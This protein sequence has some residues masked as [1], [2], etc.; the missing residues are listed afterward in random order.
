MA[1]CT[2]ALGVFYFFPAEFVRNP[3]REKALQRNSVVA[4]IESLTVFPVWG[5]AF[6]VTGLF[7]LMCVVH[8]QLRKSENALPIAH[9]MISVV[10]A[11]YTMA[12]FMTA[13]IN[14]RTFLTTTVFSLIALGANSLM[15]WWY[16]HRR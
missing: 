4:F 13:L 15:F 7:L 10:L 11:G 2:V 5:I 14:P 12:L 6:T 8:R 16:T 9:L 3:D 1:L